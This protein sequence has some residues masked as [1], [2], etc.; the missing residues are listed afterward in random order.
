MVMLNGWVT[1][2]IGLGFTEAD[3]RAAAGSQSFERGVHYL[4]AVVA[5]EIVGNQ[6]IATV[7]GSQDYLVV[8]TLG[9][10]TAGGARLRAEC[11][12]PYGQEGFFCKHCVAVSLTLLRDAARV[13]AQRSG[14]AGEAGRPAS[15][16]PDA[17]RA[18]PEPGAEADP[19]G[20]G[21]WLRSLSSDE[22]IVIV[23]E[24]AIEDEDWLRRLSLRAATAAADI[25]AVTAR[26]CELLLDD[27][28]EITGDRLTGPYGYLEGQDSWRY[29]RR[30]EEVTAA[31]QDLA[32]AGHAADATMI[33]EEA[34]AAIADVSKHASDRAGV[35]ADAAGELLAAHR[36]ACEAA[37]ADPAALADFLADRIVRADEIPEIDLADYHYL[38]GEPGLDRL[39]ARVSAAWTANPAGWAERLAMEQVLTA[40]GDVDALVE[41]LAANLDQRGLAHLR[42]VEVLDEAGRDDDALAWAERGVREAAHPDSRLADFVV[43]RYCAAGRVDDAVRVRRERF[44]AVPSV[45]AYRLLRDVAEQAGLWEPTREWALGVLRADAARMQA[46]SGWAPEPVLIDVLIADGD[47]DSAWESAGGIASDAQWLRLA[48]LIAETRPAD[49]LAVYRRQI[50]KLRSQTGDRTYDLIAQLLTSARECH[51]RLGT[52]QAFDAYLRALRAEQKR[53]PKLMRI[54][55]AHQL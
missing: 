51:R 2:A 25:P 20:L 11:G 48:D 54:L 13:P 31:V 50:D 37:P 15:G 12:C 41:M 53:K 29:A 45:A 9:G 52:G 55:K 6:V 18:A 44:R 32:E 5:M 3:V 33:A 36:Q 34:L 14:R 16:D 10:A 35:I 39:R 17:P 26:V 46:T 43:G 49:A 23:C 22:L 27:A 21:R 42:I 4:G 7:R 24:Q 19:T 28:D 30:I 8:L 40:V 47:V 1:T 38:L